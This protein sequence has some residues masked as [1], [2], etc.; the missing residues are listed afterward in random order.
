M[1]IYDEYGANRMIRTQHWKYIH[2]YPYGPHE[3]YQLDQDP[4]EL[5]NLVNDPLY[6]EVKKDLKKRLINWFCTYTDIRVDAA[7]EAVTGFGQLQK[8]GQ[9]SDGG[10]I[11]QQE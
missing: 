5:I 11:Y 4:D 9:Y 7:H 8:A 10:D 6:A 3:L 2:R 1:I